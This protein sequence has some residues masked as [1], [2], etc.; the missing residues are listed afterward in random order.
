VND[1]A[2][3]HAGGIV[4]ANSKLGKDDAV[5]TVVARAYAHPVLPGRTVV[6][7]CAEGVA[8]GDE[9][10]M[11]TLGFAT[12]EDRGTVGKERKRPLGFP[13]W[14]LVNDPKNARYA[15]DVVKE[16]KKHARKAKSK[17]GHAKD[18]FD[19]IAA[20]LSKTVPH[21]LPSF[22][23]EVG[24]VFIEHGAISY[25]AQMFGK[26]R[27][28]ES[29]HALE[30][31]EQHRID[32]FLEFALAGAVTTKALS[33]YGKDL[34]K[35]HE[36]KAA[37]THFRQLCVQRTLGGMPPWSGMAKDLSRLA[38]AAKLDVAKEDAAL[39][40]EIIESPALAKAAGEFWRA[41]AEPI[42]ALGK[43]S[44]A[45]RGVLLDLF[46]TGTSTN[47]NSELDDAWLDLLEATGAIDALIGEAP[48]EAQPANGRAAWFD[49]LCSHV[50]R[51]WRSQLI[52]PRVFA[53]LRRMAPALIAD[54]KPIKGASRY[55]VDLD[56]AELALELGIAVE[57]ADNASADGSKW[58]ASVALAEHGR[59]PVR[60]AAHPKLG[61][62]LQDVVA[63]SIG[64][65]VFDIATRGKAGFLSAKRQWLETTLAS[66][67]SGALPALE[68]ALTIIDAKA[69]AGT[70]AELPDLY[71]RLAAIDVAAA[72]A[73]TLQVGLLDEFG[74]PALE[75]VIAELRPDPTAPLL[76]LHGG[77]SAVVLA[78]ATK[79]IAIVGDERKAEHD[80]VVPPK[81]EVCA[82]RYVDGQ[83]LVVLKEGYAKIRAYWSSA[84]QDMFD[85][86]GLNQWA[87]SPTSST[88]ATL[89]DGAWYEGHRPIRPGDRV[90]PF[91][92]KIVAT[93]G[94]TGWIADYHGGEHRWR[95]L[96]LT[97]E[98]GRHSWPA[99]IEAFAADGWKL[100]PSSS[101]LPIHVTASPL[102]AAGGFTGARIRSRIVD[103]R[104]ERA[105]ESI[106][107]AS[108]TMPQPA[109]GLLAFPDGGARRPINQEHAYGEHPGVVIYDPTGTFVGSRAWGGDTRYCRG[110]QAAIPVAFL[111]NYVARDVAGSRRLHAVTVDDARALLAAAP[112]IEPAVR[113]STAGTPTEL[114]VDLPGMLPEITHPRL[115]QGLAGVVI[116]A[117][118]FE[119]RRDKLVATR[120]PG[121]A[122]AVAAA[123]PSDKMLL[124]MLGGWAR[125]Q[126]APEGSGWAQIARVGEQL[127]SEDRSDRV[128]KGLGSSPFD[129]LELA[130]LPS[131]LIFLALAVG[132][133]ADKRL[134][135][136][137]LYEHLRAALPPADKLRVLHVHGEL[138]GEDQTKLREFQVRWVGGNAYVIRPWGYSGNQY[139]LVEYAPS[140]EFKPLVG[141][142]IDSEL[143]GLAGVAAPEL[144]AAVTAGKTSWSPEIADRLAAA[145]G[146]TT[147]E[148]AFL[149]AGSPCANDH[150]ANFLDKDLRETLGLKAVQAAL[151]RDALRV[152]RYAT[153]LAPI[154][155]AGGAGV[156]ALLD[157]SAVD[158]LAAAW[159]KR[160]GQRVAIPEALIEKANAQDLSG[161]PPIVLGWVLDHESPQLTVDGHYGFDEN[162]V[163]NRVASPEPLV[164]QPKLVDTSP[165]FDA[166]TVQMLAIYL[167]FLYAELPVG[168]PV[169]AL[170]V[171]SHELA[172]QRLTSPSLWVAAGARWYEQDKLDPIWRQLEGLGG[173]IL[174]GVASERATLRRIPGG[175][176]ARLGT[177]LAVSVRP[178]ELDAKA[179]Q[180]LDPVLQQVGVVSTGRDVELL[181]SR[182]LAA[183]MARITDTPVPAG[184]WEQNPLL[185]VPKLVDKVSKAKQLSREAAALYLQYLVLL[186]PTA[187]HL[188]EYSAWTPKQL[189]AAQAELVD[190]ELLLEA[191]RERAGRGHFLPGGW[192]AYKAPLPPNESWKIAMYP[193]SKVIAQ[194]PFH[195]LFERAWKRIED[196][197][198][199]RYEEVKR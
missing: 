63:G 13:G 34:S 99:W 101:Y 49:K 128:I 87:I 198:E 20:T 76:N 153:K 96:G 30:V 180:F 188:A 36:P 46:P 1:Q 103:G 7:L 160:F 62:V 38:K 170:A 79:A 181:R 89:A 50:S 15:L 18:A 9:L 6:R 71:P 45:V 124:D 61:R 129:W 66:A 68:A 90:S 14:C 58:A 47:A 22:Y 122:S 12:G 186:R 11:S 16:L 159:T 112:V 184:G 113:T 140:G 70:F 164:G 185:S 2:T 19:A 91:T 141:L 125:Q 192:E 196:G 189:A 138:A 83:F 33:E 173:E 150:G 98:L 177:S 162:G 88:A 69:S 171:K 168:D 26:A 194:E 41:Y 119:A 39:I 56:L 146:L 29:V 59:D 155:A 163:L 84:P 145:T 8:A 182:E 105:I 144:R 116:T 136:V 191:K 175:V 118:Q 123:G 35:H 92:H 86:E 97:G 187:K 74:W 165:H 149:W 44:A 126:Y 137:E 104:Y 32:G 127:A 190:K 72:L 158:V 25:A 195:A 111:H 199:P 10:E 197:D 31:D 80:L 28:V 43:G 179:K 54:G 77:P 147:S 174:S 176:I 157:G 135:A 94:A 142:I 132:T 17:P 75:A 193:R 109:I 95:E 133:P 53:L 169:R 3:L 21:F 78:T 156:A 148:A 114:P 37:Y 23:E 4:P 121:K 67:A 5:D 172:L 161:S 167:P 130:A 107:G 64:N 65:E 81:H 52:P 73:R 40:A 106:D 115:R 131:S 82:I 85:V 139:H 151:A 93:D 120:E 55:R 51:G 102:G 152:P 42:T 48:A 178:S 134:L 24:R 154:A 108:L 143:R 27:Q 60:V 100:E 166:P 110:Q 117:K 183:M 57:P